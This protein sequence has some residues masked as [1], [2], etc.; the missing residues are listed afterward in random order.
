MFETI[1]TLFTIGFWAV[2]IFLFVFGVI[3]CIGNLVKGTVLEQIMAIIAVILG[4]FTFF[5]MY[6][7][8]GSIAWC[9]LTSGLVFGFVAGIF[10]DKGKEIQPRGNKYG[11]SDAF[12]D[13]YVEEKVIEEAVTNAIRKSKE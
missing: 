2:A 8:S 5:L 3:I 11:L 10:S 12:L 1:G 13:A 6:D 7:W 9:L 4:I